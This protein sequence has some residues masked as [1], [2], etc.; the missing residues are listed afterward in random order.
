[1]PNS[2]DYGYVTFAAPP[3]AAGKLRTVFAHTRGYYR[4]HLSPTNPPDSV[5]L[6]RFL[7][8]PDAAARFAVAQYAQSHPRV[9]M[10]H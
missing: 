10:A 7:A 3:L 6:A 1:M 9:A 8:V 5:T 4:L 2:G